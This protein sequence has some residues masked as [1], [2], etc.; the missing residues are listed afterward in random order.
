MIT[1]DKFRTNKI[2]NGRQ[3]AISIFFIII[4]EILHDS[5]SK[6]FCSLILHIFITY[7]RIIF[8]YILI[9]I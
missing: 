8:G 5:W 2:L 4:S 7:H 3:S 1:H 6:Y 9:P